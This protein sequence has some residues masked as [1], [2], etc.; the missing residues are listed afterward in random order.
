V[1]DGGGD[2]V[3]ACVDDDDDDDDARARAKT[4]VSTN[5]R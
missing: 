4:R 5:E 2:G 1:R 3:D